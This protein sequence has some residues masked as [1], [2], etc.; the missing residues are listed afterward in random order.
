MA[1]DLLDVEISLVNTENRELLRACLQSLP[2]ACTGLRWRA[3]VVDNA[4]GDGSAGMVRA[5]FPW[6]GLLAS[7]WRLG[8]SANHNQVLRRVLEDGGARYVLI[9]NEDTALDPGC[10]GELVGLCDADRR[11]GA[12]GPVI[13]G[14]DGRVQ[15]SHFRFP[16]VGQQAWAALRPRSGPRPARGTGWLNGSCILIR[17]DALRQ[18]GPLDERFFI[19][20]EDTDLGLRLE[21][22]GWASAVCQSATML[23]HGHETV[24]RPALGSAME[25]QMLRSRYLYFCKHRGQ[26]RA[27]ALQ[28]ATRTAL[29]ARALKALG[30]AMLGREEPATARL[31]A[32]LA[33]Y[34]PRTPLPH[35]RHL[36]RGS[37]AA[38]AAR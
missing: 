24:S 31:L 3:T 23:H 20:Y 17:T 32:G 21:R 15:Q 4:S 37:V 19:F 29:L 9:L 18:V 35:E 26:A 6:A 10:V 25:R 38:G 30:E 14:R 36:A 27:A 8:F 5:E 1:P 11:I 2:E 13:R 34:D 22:A 28:L 33:G 12:A 16:T 7:E